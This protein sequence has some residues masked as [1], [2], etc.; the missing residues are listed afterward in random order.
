[1]CIH[2]HT[3]EHVDAE[4]GAELRQYGLTASIGVESERTSG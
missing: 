1:M 2:A 3:H 4:E